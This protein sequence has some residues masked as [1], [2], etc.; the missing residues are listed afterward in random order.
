MHLGTESWTMD[1]I[2]WFLGRNL[3]MPEINHFQYN[4][5]VGYITVVVDSLSQVPAFWA[6]P[7]AGGPF[8]GLILLHDDW[9]L[10]E[11]MRA[12]AHRFA[13]VGYYVMIPDLFEGNRATNQIQADALEIRYKD[14]ALPKVVAALRALETHHK[15][16]SKMAVLGWDLGAEVA[17][18]L[19]LERPDIMA[20]IA[21]YGD[22]QRYFARLDQ[23]DCPMLQIY[24]ADDPL[25]PSNVEPLREKLGASKQPHEVVVYPEADHGFYNDMIPS[26][27]AEA[28]QNAWQKILIFL[29][30]HQGAPPRP[31]EAAPGYFRPGK[32]Y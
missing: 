17:T 27:N 31:D 16:N 32:V 1:F 13:E 19:C 8:P 22:I 18:E 23:L 20:G 14:L 11:H 6:H 12:L 24:G 15:C 4:I 10:S 30:T 21:F 2:D 3:R 26:Y 7:Q 9:G 5:T 25:T 29:K 28:A